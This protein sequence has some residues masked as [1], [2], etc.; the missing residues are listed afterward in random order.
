ML[1]K[2][3]KNDLSKN[4]RKNRDLQLRKTKREEILNVKRS[5][6]SPSGT[7]HVVVS[8]LRFIGKLDFS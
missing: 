6:G 8:L 1:G 7:P 4:D 2:K 3:A 5:I